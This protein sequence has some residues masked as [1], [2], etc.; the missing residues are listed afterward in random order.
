[1]KAPFS[2]RLDI[3]FSSNILAAG[4]L[5]VDDFEYMGCVVSSVGSDGTKLGLGN[6]RGSKIG[7]YDFLRVKRLPGVL[8]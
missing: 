7:G 4:S 3:D 1:L 8:V 2:S 5:C 6:W